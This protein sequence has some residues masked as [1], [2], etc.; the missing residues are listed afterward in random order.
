MLQ[1]LVD[2]P[3]ST[4]DKTVPRHEARLSD[5][6]LT[7]IVISKLPRASRNGI[8]RAAWEKE[9]VEQKWSQSAYAKRKE[10]TEK[11]RQ[12][13]DF[14]RFKVMRLKKQVSC[15]RPPGRFDIDRTTG[16]SQWAMMSWTLTDDS[17]T[18]RSRSRSRRSAPRRK[19]V[20]SKGEERRLRCLWHI[21]R[22][23]PKRLYVLVSWLIC[24]GGYGR[25]HTLLVPY[26]KIESVQHPLSLG[27]S[28]GG[29]WH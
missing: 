15:S 22:H 4:A 29:T 26:I 17:P 14:E 20:E 9:G 19:R 24:L 10:R 7:P 23:W 18:S 21:R 27:I 13:T 28:Q 2:G 25:L 5:V 3:A 8:V 12:L 11:R 6:S 16:P 1:V